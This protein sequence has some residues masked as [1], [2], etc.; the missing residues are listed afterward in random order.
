M[1][2]TFLFALAFGALA[3]SNIEAQ[4]YPPVPYVYGVSPFQDSMWSFNVTNFAM[5]TTARMAPFLSGFTITGMNGLALD[6]CS[7]QV[8]GIA[9]VS[10]V[11]GRVLVTMDVNTG[12]CTQVGNLG[13]NFSSITFDRNGQLYGATGDGATA[14]ESLFSIDKVTGT[15]TLITAMG[16]GA[17]GEIICHNPF[18]DLL[19]HWSGNGTV[20]YESLAPVAPYTPTN[21]PI[22]G[23]A[24]GETF[25]AL[26]WSADTFL[27]SNISSRF[28]FITTAGAYTN[29]V[30]NSSPDD[31]RG[32]VL[33]PA[34][35]EDEDTICAGESIN[36][37]VA[38]AKL[39]N[40]I[41]H[42]GDGSSDTVAMG[43][44][45]HNRSHTY[46]SAG[47]YTITVTLDNGYCT[48]TNFYTKLIRVNA[49][50]SV[51]VSGSTGICPGGSVTLMGTSG[52]SSQWYMNGVAVSSATTN[53]YTTSIPGT[54]NMIKT[55]ANG[56]ADSAAVGIT[57]IDVLNP[58]VD[59]G[60][61]TDACVSLTLDAQNAG[62]NYLWSDNSTGQTLTA[63]VS[64]TYSVTV[65]DT[66]G[67]EGSDDITLTINPLPSVS[68][69][70]T[71]TICDGET[72][73]L[74]TATAGT[75][76]WYQDGSAI[77]GA[78]NASVDISVAGNYNVMVTDT[79]NCADTA[80]V[81]FALT[82]N[83]LPIVSVSGDAAFCAGDDA[84]MTASPA[85]ANGYQWYLNGNM[86]NGATSASYTTNQ[87]GSYNVE[88]TDA[89]G[90]ID[91][92]PLSFDVVENA[93]PTVTYVELQDTVCG[94]SG[95]ISLT[96]ATPAGG[97]YSG[98]SVMAGTFDTDIAPGTYTI[99][100]TYTDGNGC[101]N[102]A[103][104]D[105]VVEICG[106]VQN[107]TNTDVLVYPNPSNGLFTLSH[108]PSDAQVTVVNVLG[109][110]VFQTN[111][112]SNNTL[113]LQHLGNGCYWL[114]LQ[115]DNML[116]T[117]KITIQR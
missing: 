21:I 33:Y 16:N 81:A 87:A 79:N 13:D 117:S 35:A 53:T 68:I 32:M 55:N 8:Y 45:T 12:V 98:T 23:A 71:A 27:I 49:L 29:N 90:C 4:S 86:V 5:T 107:I 106:G 15:T 104:D 114:R 66:Y 102:A 40:A 70:G 72:S 92:A 80:A 18:V 44:L 63:T 11:S 78:T 82:V 46:S 30:G 19:Y 61:V 43:N 22:S 101:T 20:V 105:V 41:Y 36:V 60:S 75:Y 1:K 89:N 47:N 57:V 96:A 37:M 9:K 85:G 116:F 42:W 31:I 112:I 24:G 38:G 59:L 52:G 10:G 108:A 93:L 91:D 50:P 110:V 67:C 25:G 113:D 77:G 94:L 51:V 111:N 64:G 26:C 28:A 74:S 7:M 58:T 76:Q 65:T 34:I 88:V 2:K 99:T 48:G 17:D 83:S 115:T 56:C 3:T 39:F 84:T 97:I 73:T 103:S 100:Y 14:P 109:G 69:S 95:I 54:Y 6:P 62:S